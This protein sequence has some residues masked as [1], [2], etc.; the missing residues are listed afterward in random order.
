MA[1]AALFTGWG[2]PVRGRE[3]KGLEVF[4]EAV[5]FWSQ[6]KEAGDI[7]SFDVVLLQ[8]HGGDLNG[9]ILAK[10][11]EEQVAA[12]RNSDEFGRLTAR[13]GLIV[14]KLGVLDAVTGDAIGEQIGMYQQAIGDLA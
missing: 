13:A 14:E 4:G 5:A 1:D 8:T 11:S 3:A 10:G 7:A 9:F 2:P 12:I 6:R